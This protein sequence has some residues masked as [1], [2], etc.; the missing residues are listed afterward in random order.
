METKKI[1]KEV[2]NYTAPIFSNELFALLGDNF[3]SS[4]VRNF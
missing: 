3:N 1:P 2:A 4:I